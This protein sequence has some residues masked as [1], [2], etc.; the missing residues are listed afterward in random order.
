MDFS[1]LKKYDPEIMEVIE[2]KQI[3]REHQLI[4]SENFCHPQ[5]ME[6]MVANQ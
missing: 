3:G 5:V 6:A 1:N 2:L 4:V